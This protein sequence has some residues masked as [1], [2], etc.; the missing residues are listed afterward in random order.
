MKDEEDEDKDLDESMRT[1]TLHSDKSAFDASTVAKI[2]F[3]LYQEWNHKATSTRMTTRTATTKA[4]RFSEP[5]RDTKLSV[6]RLRLSLADAAVTAGGAVL[7]VAR[8]MEVNSNV[9]EP[10]HENT[11]V[12]NEESQDRRVS[13]VTNG[14]LC[15][16]YTVA[17]VAP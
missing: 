15:R 12:Q 4:S 5:N 3:P 16:L 1:S 11:K 14:G 8:K 13:A 9:R 10:A 6:I 2:I 7:A 17:L